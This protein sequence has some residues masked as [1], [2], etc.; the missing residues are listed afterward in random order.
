SAMII[1]ALPFLVMGAVKLSS[2]DYLDP[3]FNTPT[4]NFILLG[5]GLWMGM[6]IFVMKSMMKIKV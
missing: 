3:L 6:G 1:G 5:A 2:P 4:G